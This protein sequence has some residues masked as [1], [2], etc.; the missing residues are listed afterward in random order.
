MPF[1]QRAVHSSIP[2]D[3]PKHLHWGYFLTFFVLGLVPAAL[4]PT[5]ITLAQQTGSELKDVSILFSM[6]SLGYLCS[7]RI[8]GGL[9]DKRAGHPIMVIALS[10]AVVLMF[11]IPYITSLGVLSG[12]FLLHGI[13]SAFIDLGGNILLIWAFHKNTGPYLNG[14]HFS[15]GVGAFTAPLLVAFTLSIEQPPVYTYWIIGLLSLPCI[16]W[17][18]RTPSPQNPFPQEEEKLSAEETPVSIWLLVAFFFLYGGSEVSLG[19]WIHTYGIKHNLMEPAKAAYLTSSFWG[20]FTLGRLF[21][22]R[23]ASKFAAIKLILLQLSG[24]ALFMLLLFS[25][26]ANESITW[27]CTIVT[28]L[29][30]SSVFPMALTYF[31]K[32]TAGSGQLT[33]WFWIGASSGSMIL[34]WTIGQFFEKIGPEFFAITIFVCITSATLIMAYIS[35]PRPQLSTANE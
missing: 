29:C 5:L 30:M 10:A 8:I 24:A 1:F 19:G 31:K 33:S 13:L 7:A 14:L 9:Y 27:V 3:P 32:F 11:T 26:P 2:N 25:V 4:G 21:A 22:I 6:R 17:L 23:L 20:A 35:R 34:P 18:S 15:F 16:L 28:G 12:A